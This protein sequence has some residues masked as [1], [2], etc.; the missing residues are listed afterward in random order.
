MPVE[1]ILCFNGRHLPQRDGRR[2]APLA[3]VAGAHI[4]LCSDG[5]SRQA[6]PH[7]N[8]LVGLEHCLFNK[9]KD[10]DM[11]KINGATGT[12]RLHTPC[13]IPWKRFNPIVV[14]RGT[15]VATYEMT[16]GMHT[17]LQSISGK[18]ITLSILQRPGNKQQRQDVERGCKASLRNH[19]HNALASMP[20]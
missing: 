17:H 15:A 13:T 9:R 19:A 16:I 7:R 14:V 4:A 11:A 20:I 12:Q 3:S 6:S 18:H 5:Q 2:L 8:G 10:A 1:E